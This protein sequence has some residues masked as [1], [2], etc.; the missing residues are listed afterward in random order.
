MPEGAPR[1]RL[2]YEPDERPGW[3]L[4]LGLG[5]QS[6]IPVLVGTA[7]VSV[8]T[9]RSGGV[10]EPYVRWAV[11]TAL[12]V[13]GLTTMLQ[14]VRTLRLG[15][16]HPMAMVSSGSFIAVSATALRLGGPGLLASLVLASSCLQIA[17]ANRLAALRRLLT[18]TVCGTIIMLIP[19]AVL[20]IAFTMLEDAAASAPGGA[21]R[22]CSAVTLLVIMVLTLRGT[23]ALRIWAPLIGIASGS[24][25]AIPLDLY[26]FGPVAAAD[27]IGVPTGGWPGI[28]PSLGSR[29]WALLPAFLF[30]AL[31]NTV[32]TIGDAN[33]LQA[34]S[35]R[36]ARAPDYRVAQGAITASGVGNLFCGVAGVM[37]NV[38]YSASA[39]A[40]GLTGVAARRV[41]VTTGF[42]LLAL[43][44][45]PKVAAILLA[46]PDA[47]ISAYLVVVFG[48]LFVGGMEMA[49][50]DG[51]NVR[52]A[53]IVGVSFWIGV[54]FGQGAILPEDPSS[55]WVTLLTDGI[56]V[57]ALAALVFTGFVE[58]TGPRPR[59]LTAALDPDAVPTIEAFLK[60]LA[61]RR[62]WSGRSTDRLIGA[63]E[64]AVLLLLEE[65]GARDHAAPPR[66]RLTARTGRRSAELE[67]VAAGG[68]TNIED[69]LA[70]VV[71]PVE[72]PRE[73]EVS[74]R[75]L[76]HY[77]RTVRHRKYHN[78]DIVTL[79][80][81]ADA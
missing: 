11:F 38:A 37:P 14:S 27:W 46:I 21:V 29:F 75:L 24:L 39:S 4:S 28:A 3:P 33:A 55:L 25:V 43:A 2:R 56:S 42:V 51:M 1:A 48:V 71:G 70:L 34:A 81:D 32:K 73:E 31:V 57:G 35:W 76:R 52:R 80:V 72:T 60:D 64:E 6:A 77:A 5:L 16:G 49:A 15:S 74:L 58:I 47:V 9:A 61:V 78:V 41:A 54:G 13:G 45:S 23:D 20:P 19:V 50:R 18:P 68:D 69:R 79:T 53:T 62:G 59:R 10:G 66:L 65:S 12:V 7:V 36:T 26:D 63:A 8:I 40:V 44:L 22:L 67:F 30:V 17:L